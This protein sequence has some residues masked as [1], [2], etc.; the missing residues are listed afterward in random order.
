MQPSTSQGGCVSSKA[1]KPYG[2]LRDLSFLSAG[3]VGG[4]GAAYHGNRASNIVSRASG[5]QGEQALLISNPKPSTAKCENLAELQ[6]FQQNLGAVSS[7]VS[8]A[9]R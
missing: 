6:P 3:S 5:L 2:G 4:Q 7:F 9:A 1:G 8:G